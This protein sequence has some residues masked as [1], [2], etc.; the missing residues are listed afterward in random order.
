M[1]WR[2]VFLDIIDQLKTDLQNLTDGNGNNVF[3][4]VYV[5]RK[6]KPIHF[7]C[8]FIFPG[9]VR[10]T[11]STVTKSTY[12]MNVT[13][14]VVS[15][16]AA[17]ESGLKDVLTR[18]GYVEDMLKSDRTFHG[19]VDNLEVDTIETEVFRPMVRERHEAELTVRFIRFTM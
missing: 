3:A 6:S 16:I 8:A 10:L 14:R 11:P 5:G 17:G 18:L 1:S 19:Y 9:R 13:I 12:E 2:E 4:A 15:K 7:P